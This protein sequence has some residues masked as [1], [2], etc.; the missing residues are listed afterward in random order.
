MTYYPKEV[1]NIREDITRENMRRYD[2]WFEK[3]RAKQLEIDPDYYDRDL[4]T[5]YAIAEQAKAE[6][7]G[8]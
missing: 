4:R 8:W 3:V 2:T 7:G 6:I 5:R 1:Y